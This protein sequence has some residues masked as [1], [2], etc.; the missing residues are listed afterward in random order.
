[1]KEIATKDLQLPKEKWRTIL[2]K[3]EIKAIKKDSRDKQSKISTKRAKRIIP[4]N[5][6]KELFE[7]RMTKK[8]TKAI[9]DN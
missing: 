7:N 3:K 2:T 5:G 1:M 9:A 4:E 6:R 8:R